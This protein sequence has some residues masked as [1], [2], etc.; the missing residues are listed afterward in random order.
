[1]E[2]IKIYTD[3]AC[4]GNPGRGGWGVFII[5]GQESKKIFGGKKA[6]K[7]PFPHYVWPEKNK[8]LNTSVYK[9]L[10]NMSY[11]KTDAP[12]FVKDLNTNAL[13][14]TDI[15]SLKSHRK[16]IKNFQYKQ[17]EINTLRK[18]ISD[19]KEEMKELKQLFLQK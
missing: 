9:Y 1:M 2:R 3:G 16:M 8:K 10:N 11:V 15:E 19:I 7:I 13:L 14:R 12:G 6:V 17:D 4:R 5:N 18:E